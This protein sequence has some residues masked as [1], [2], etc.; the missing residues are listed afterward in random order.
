[1]LN[2]ES[3]KSKVASA[4]HMEK[5]LAVAYRVVLDDRALGKA[6]GPQCQVH[7]RTIVAFV[8]VNVQDTVVQ[9]VCPSCSHIGV[10]YDSYHFKLVD[11][12]VRKK[13]TDDVIRIDT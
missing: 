8:K 7:S 5:H 10:L 12:T 3:L 1:M 13:E 4:P 2:M 6:V 11:H 9:H